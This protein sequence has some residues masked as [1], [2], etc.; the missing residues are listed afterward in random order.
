MYIIVAAQW[1]VC[2][3]LASL[4]IIK[5]KP[6]INGIYTFYVDKVLKTTEPGKHQKPLQCRNIPATRNLYI[7][8]PELTKENLEGNKNQVTLSYAYPH[9]PINSQAIARYIKLFFRTLWNRCRN[10]HSTFN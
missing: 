5:I 1:T 6:I 4:E 10:I 3:I 9:K 7:S 8:R 2:A